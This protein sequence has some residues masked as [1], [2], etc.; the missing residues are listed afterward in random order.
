M[1]NSRI[2]FINNNENSPAYWMF[3]ILWVIKA[4]SFQTDNNFSLIEQ[5]MPF[6]SGPPPHYHNDMDEMFYIMEGEMTIW[7]E[8]EIYKLSAGTFAMIP[9]GTV[10]YFKI[11]S[12]IPCRALNMYTPGGFEKGIIRNGQETKNLSLP[13]AELPYHGSTDKNDMHVGVDIVP[14]DLIA[15]SESLG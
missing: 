5:T 9:K 2:S 11:T 14:I 4:Q 7:I 1:N 10:H 3:D 15:Q 12:Q 6:N 13:P 8:G